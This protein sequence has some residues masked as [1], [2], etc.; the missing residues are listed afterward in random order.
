[1]FKCSGKSICKGYC[2][3]L[4]DLKVCWM[5]EVQCGLSVH[6]WDSYHQI[7]EW[8]GQPTEIISG[9]GRQRI[10]HQTVG[11]EEPTKYVP[12]RNPHVYGR[13]S[14]TKE[15]KKKK[16]WTLKES[17]R[18]EKYWKI[19][20]VKFSFS[21]FDSTILDT[22]VKSWDFS[23]FSHL[24]QVEL[25]YMLPTASPSP[26]PQTTPLQLTL[27]VWLLLPSPQANHQYSWKNSL[28][29]PCAQDRG[30][31]AS[32]RCWGMANPTFDFNSS[33]NCW[34][35]GDLVCDNSQGVPGAGCPQRPNA[36]VGPQLLPFPSSLYL[37]FK[38]LLRRNLE[39][40]IVSECENL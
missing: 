32:G 37:R 3:I 30:N 10:C 21:F 19:E 24:L 35:E 14:E 27:S 26:C 6:W 23:M 36:S 18:R 9:H 8:F 20:E 29:S 17:Q 33:P 12:R 39:E 16:T 1:M 2:V 34:L 11:R 15:R 31:R 5:V 25:L 7:K 38:V 13:C 28:S 40:R 22:S 4:I